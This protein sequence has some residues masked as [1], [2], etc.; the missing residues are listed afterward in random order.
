MWILFLIGLL[1]CNFSFAQEYYLSSDGSYYY[2]SPETTTENYDTN[3]VVYTTGSGYQEVDTSLS[4]NYTSRDQILQWIDYYAEKY[5]LPKRT[6]RRLA[7]RESRYTT[8]AVSRSNAVGVMQIIVNSH[9]G[10]MAELG[11]TDEDLLNPE[12]NI[13][14]GCLILRNNLNSS[15]SMKGAL[16]LYA[17]GH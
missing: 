4:S 8:D 9:R 11:M 13:E 15:G 7:H 5:G 16:R 3:G 1:W 12:K 17:K 14:L 10:E 6:V 2:L